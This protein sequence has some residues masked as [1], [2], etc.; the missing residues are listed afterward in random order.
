VFLILKCPE[1]V[2]PLAY[3]MLTGDTTLTLPPALLQDTPPTRHR[4][5]GSYSG[6]RGFVR[7]EASLAT[8]LQKQRKKAKTKPVQVLDRIRIAEDNNGGGSSQEEGSS[9]ESQR[10]MTEAGVGVAGSKGG[11]EGR[12]FSESRERSGS[13][14]LGDFVDV[15]IVDSQ[16]VLIEPSSDSSR[17]S[18]I[19]E[20]FSIHVHV[21]CSQLGVLNMEGMR[22]YMYAFIV[23][24]YMT[25]AFTEYI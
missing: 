22:L 15:S 19:P 24:V 11:A 12:G 5:D 21:H 7:P 2:T 16:Y 17:T 18:S 14:S 13:S 4:R 9:T 1:V 6:I 10:H 23:H 25:C 3:L 8:S 20:V